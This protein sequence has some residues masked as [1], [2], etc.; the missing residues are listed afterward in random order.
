M[1]CYSCSSMN[2]EA[3]GS[4]NDVVSSRQKTDYCDFNSGYYCMV[5]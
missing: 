5:M 4:C 2:R 3:E 1:T